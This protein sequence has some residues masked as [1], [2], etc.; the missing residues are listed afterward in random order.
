MI[1]TGFVPHG[2]RLNDGG[3]D[4]EGYFCAVLSTFSYRAMAR[5][6]YL[7]NRQGSADPRRHQHIQ[8]ACVVE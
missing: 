4:P 3:C 1:A 2:Q 6:P 8:R 5:Y 7:A